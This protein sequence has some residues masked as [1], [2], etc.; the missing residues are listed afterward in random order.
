MKKNVLDETITGKIN[1]NEPIV[2]ILHS[3]HERRAWQAFL[4]SSRN[5][6][7]VKFDVLMF[8]EFHKHPNTHKVGIC[9]TDYER[10]SGLHQ[11]LG[12][13]SIKMAND[14]DSQLICVCVDKLCFTKGTQ[15]FQDSLVATCFEMALAKKLP[16]FLTHA[17][18]GFEAFEQAYDKTYKADFITHCQ[19]FMTM[20]PTQVMLRN[21]K[22]GL[23]I[24]Q[25]SEE[26]E[27]LATLQVRQDQH[28]IFEKVVSLQGNQLF[29]SLTTDQPS[30][31]AF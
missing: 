8:D 7:S 10:I 4:G 20:T 28:V 5:L 26:I 13:Y 15:D 3:K 27:L 11:L 12:G 30:D 1:Y 24:W 31:K 21:K 17:N 19:T 14:Y 2:C 23:F 25:R 22:R 9:C 29:C 6:A 18:D 16:V